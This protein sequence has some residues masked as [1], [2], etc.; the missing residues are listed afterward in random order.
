M[1]SGVDQKVMTLSHPLGSAS[2]S[3]TLHGPA[4]FPILSSVSIVISLR[5]K[6][7]LWRIS[8]VRMICSGDEGRGAKGRQE[9]GP[10]VAFFF[11][12][13]FVSSL[14]ACDIV[15]GSQFPATTDPPQVARHRQV[16]AP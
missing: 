11:F 3:L 13:F 5:V 2:A 15:H 9:N 12:F 6:K 1:A 8:L 16:V 14:I 7:V 4:L 10:D